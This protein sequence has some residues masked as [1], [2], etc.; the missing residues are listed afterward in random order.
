MNQR[1]KKFDFFDLVR[2]QSDVLTLI[3]LFLI[4]YLLC[5]NV[6]ISSTNI[7]NIL[8]RSAVLGVIAIGQTLVILTGGI[9]LS[10]AANLGL[11]IAINALFVRLG[12]NP[13]DA[14]FLALLFPLIVGFINGLIIANT[15]LPPFI[16]TL[17]IMN[18]VYSLNIAAIG[19][20]ATEFP[21]V[22]N[23]FI[24]LMRKTRIFDDRIF[25]ILIWVF[26]SIFF[27]LFLRYSRFGYNIYTIGS[28]EVNAKFSGINIKIVKIG[29]YSLSGF[30]SGVAALLFIAKLGGTNP[31]AG[32]EF[33]L[34]SI[35]ATVIGGTSL[36]GGEGKISGTVVGAVAMSILVNLMNL[37]GVNPFIQE[38]VIGAIFIIFVFT[39]NQIRNLRVIR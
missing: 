18:I 6:F 25:P 34:E 23:F 16:V 22:Q 9:D 39:L 19:T 36:A 4:S 28:S 11:Y 17:G 37:R 20:H 2:S 12:V 31:V 35:A 10:V 26:L 38:A 8:G 24:N 13:V 15:N 7:I 14:M 5:G 33:I 30:L 21:E 32:R 3:I 27:I 1:I 29:V